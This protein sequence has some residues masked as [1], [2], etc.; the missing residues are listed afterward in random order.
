MS[1]HTQLCRNE[2]ESQKAR[3][4]KRKIGAGV[5]NAFIDLGYNV[6]ADSLNIAISTFAPTDRLAVIRGDISEPAAA[7]EIVSAAMDNF[8][9]INGVVNNAGIR[10]TVGAHAGA[11]AA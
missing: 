2:T 7:R 6:V 4:T 10:F 5:T 1:Q 9:S 3:Q 11:D 8:C